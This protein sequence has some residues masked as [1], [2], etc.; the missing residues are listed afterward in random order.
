M[1]AEIR[2]LFRQWLVDES[3]ESYLVYVAGCRRAGVKINHCFCGK[4]VGTFCPIC[5]KGM[6]PKCCLDCPEHEGPD[7][8]RMFCVQ[9]QTTNR[10]DLC[11]KPIHCMGDRIPEE[12]DRDEYHCNMCFNTVL[13]SECDRSHRFDCSQCSIIVMPLC[14][15]TCGECKWGFCSSCIKHKCSDCREP[16]CDD[17]MTQCFT[18]TI[19]TCKS[20]ARNIG[21][22]ECGECIETYCSDHLTICDECSAVLCMDCEH[23][24]EEDDEEEGY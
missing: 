2:K 19:P 17:C 12:D 1:D 16:V 18:C 23:Y 22:E 3:L 14:R 21:F 24:H 10:C 13:C 15:E 7:L 5:G 4:V 8:N 20:C 6:C 11:D 9:C